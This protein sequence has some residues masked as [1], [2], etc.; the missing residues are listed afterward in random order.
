VEATATAPRRGSTFD[1]RRTDPLDLG[2]DPFLEPFDEEALAG[3]AFKRK[4]LDLEDARCAAFLVG[5][6]LVFAFDPIRAA[7]YTDYSS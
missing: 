2:F 7:T 3:F 5:F 1:G 4:D 6:D